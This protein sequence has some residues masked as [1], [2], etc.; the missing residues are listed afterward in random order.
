MGW[1][2]SLELADSQSPSNHGCEQSPTASKT[3]T[4]KAFL[5]PECGKVSLIRLQSGMTCE[6]YQPNSYWPEWISS[7]VAS[8][9]RI[10]VL[11]AAE[12]AWM[13]SEAVC[14][15]KSSDW[16][17]IFDRPSFS[18]KMSQLS[19]FEDS[20]ESSVNFPRS[21]MTVGG[22]LFQPANLE[23]V[24]EDNAGS[25]LPTPTATPYGYNQTESPN[26]K[27]RMSMQS[28]ASRGLIPTPMARDWRGSGG[29]N[30]Q[31]P[32]L[33]FT[34]GGKLNPQFVEEIMGY[35]IGWTALDASVTQW[36]QSKRA[37]PSKGSAACEAAP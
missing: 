6:H 13:E 32:D 5:C 37:K 35:Q 8:H 22:R 11:L 7:P 1:I 20:T 17:M 31:S 27:R 28:M 19:L 34:M 30:R 18:W 10:S 12:R 24:T 4:R 36:F 3:D 23:P 26:A 25:C 14:S 2:C 29:A 21:G 33:S 16:L 9:V 15:S